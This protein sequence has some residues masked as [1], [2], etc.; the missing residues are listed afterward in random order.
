MASKLLSH[1]IYFSLIVLSSLL[2]VFSFP[3]FDLGFFAWIGLLPLLIAI[4]GKNLKYGFFL[5]LV[6]GMLFFMGIF[7]WI[8]EVPKYTILHHALLAVYLGLYFAFFGLIFNF[9]STRWGTMP[10]LF[11]APFIWVSLEWVRSNLS[12]LA[13]PWA[14]LAHSQYQ[15]LAVMQIASITGAYGVSF[16]I[17]LVNAVLAAV[18]CQYYERLKIPPHL[19]FSK[20]GATAFQKEG[21]IAPPLSKEDRGE[22]RISTKEK[23]SLVIIAASLLLFTLVYGYFAITNTITGNRTKIS[24]VQGNIEQTKKWNPRYAREIMQ[25]YAGLT[26]AAAKDQPALVVWPETATPGA[27]NLNPR[28]RFE[29]KEIAKRAGTYVLLGSAQNQK[30]VEKGAKKLRNVNSAFLLDPQP[31]TME[32][33]RYDKIRLFPFGEYLPYNGIIP[34]SLINVREFTDCMPG[35]EFTVFQLPDFRFGVIICWE[36]AFPDLV[37]QFVKR[38]AQFI[39]NITNEAHFGRTA[40]PYQLVSTSVFRAVENRVFVVRCANTGV[41]CIIDPYGRIIDRVKDEKGQDIFVRGVV[42]GWIIPLDSRTIYTR[43]GDWFVWVVI[44]GSLVFLLGTWGKRKKTL[45]R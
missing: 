38:G 1:L 36:N 16:L 10:A 8:L 11:A 24:V 31:K 30:F 43:Y 21:I 29:L 19:P 5:S 14:L 7:Y 34:W 42:S 25:T 6:C 4:S 26:E 33:Q 41:S 45:C 40:A 39:I 23:L 37:R 15:Y 32:N 3:K 20:G 18:V 13:L 17:V 27:I 44:I 28:L 22:F 12:F 35:K 9:V 2:L